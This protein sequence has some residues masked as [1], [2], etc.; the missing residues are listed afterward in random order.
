[1]KG[2]HNIVHEHLYALEITALTLGMHESRAAG[3]GLVYWCSGSKY[4]C[5]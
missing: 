2:I 5:V 1:M 3:S 4:Q